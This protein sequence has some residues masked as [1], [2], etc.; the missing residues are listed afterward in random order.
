MHGYINILRDIWSLYLLSHTTSLSCL[1]TCFTGVRYQEITHHFY[2]KSD[3]EESPLIFF[4]LNTASVVRHIGICSNNKPQFSTTGNLFFVHSHFW[5]WV[6]CILQILVTS[7]RLPNPDWKEWGERESICYLGE[8]SISEFKFLY[9][10]S[11]C[12]LGVWEERAFT[13]LW[14]QCHCVSE[15]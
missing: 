10:Y 7:W 6:Y 9:G 4:Y 11:V 5:H 13:V 8:F 14:V 12:Q 2:F 15:L 1:G 3:Q